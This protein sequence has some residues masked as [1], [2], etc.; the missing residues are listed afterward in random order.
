MNPENNDPWAQSYDNSAFFDQ[1]GP[2]PRGCGGTTD[3]LWN[4][5]LSLKY[6]FTAGGL[7]MNLR[8]DVFNVTDEAGVSEVDEF[9]QEASSEVNPYYLD[10]LHFQN[11]RRVRFG[12]GLTF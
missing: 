7:D 2:C 5:D 6:D 12:V 11:P 3:D 1:N 10:P 8:V 4:L 9:A